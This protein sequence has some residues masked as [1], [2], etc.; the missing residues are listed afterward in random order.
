MVLIK[1]SQK[2]RRVDATALAHIVGD[3]IGSLSLGAG[4]LSLLLVSNRRITQ[5]NKQ[6]FD[7]NRPTNVI[8]FGYGA[9]AEGEVLGDIIISVERA[10][11][12]AEDS[13]FPFYDR[14]LALIVHG[15][16]HI[17]GFDH[18]AGAAE[19]RRMRYREQKLMAKVR[20]HP[21]YGKLVEIRSADA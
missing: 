17:A 18:E 10:A 7:R 8:S 16:V 21:I 13:G 12:E 2:Q 20:A 15:M 9:C 3:V 6:Y 1:N 19:A 14:L 5:I 11:E 4:D